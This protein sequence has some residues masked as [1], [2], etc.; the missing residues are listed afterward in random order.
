M[1][2]GDD[3]TLT[4]TFTDNDGNAIDL[5]GG[6]VFLTV[7]NRSTDSDDNAVLKKDVSSFSA[8]T[9]GIMTIDLTDSDTD[10]SAGYYWYDVQF[11]D[12]SGSV[13]SIQKDKFIVKRDI[14]NRIS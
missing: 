10:I 6:T 7:K 1:I 11:V 5:T 3:V 2:Q 8:P 4:L 14:T 12:S 9:T 13:S